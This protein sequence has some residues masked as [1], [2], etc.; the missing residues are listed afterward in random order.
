MSDVDERLL[1]TGVPPNTWSVGKPTYDLECADD[2]LLF[3][4]TASALDEYLKCV[5]VETSLCGL[6]LNLTKTEHLE[7]PTTKATP[8]QFSDGSPV[9]TADESKYLGSQVS[10]NKPSLTAIQHRINQAHVAFSKLAPYW[11]SRV[12][13]TAKVRI[14]QANVVPVLTYGLASLALEDKHYQKMI[15]GMTG[16]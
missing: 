14:F 15:L 7:H 5:Q 10:W 16:T 12:P 3:A 11:R 13:T 8:L 9:P 1:A 2:T 4:V 6:S